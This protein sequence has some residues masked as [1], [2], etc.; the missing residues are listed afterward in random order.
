MNAALCFSQTPVYLDRNAKI[1]DRVEDALSRMTLEEKV[2]L[3]HAQSKFSTAGV[4]RLGIPE[5]WMS[6]GPHGVRAE[7]NWNDWGYA[8]HTNDS[9]TAFPALTALAATWNPEMS[10]LYGKLSARRLS[11][12]RRMCFLDRV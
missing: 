8:N 12:V 3:S 1:E 7:I 10:A 9:V 4:A 6:D 11:I 5:L 2:A